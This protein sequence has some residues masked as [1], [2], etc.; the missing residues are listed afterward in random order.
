RL[1]Q[2]AT[3]GDEGTDLAAFSSTNSHPQAKGRSCEIGLG[4]PF[5]GSFFE[6]TFPGP[7]KTSS[8]TGLTLGR[9][10]RNIRVLDMKEFVPSGDDDGCQRKTS[11]ERLRRN[12]AM[13]GLRAC[14]DDVASPRIRMVG[15]D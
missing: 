11:R 4:F 3:A 8:P 12:E 10:T 5:R 15:H 14:V 7:V 1:A 9:N 13:H 6:I 2:G